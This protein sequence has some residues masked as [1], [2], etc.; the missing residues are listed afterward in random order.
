MGTSKLNIENMVGAYPV[1][2]CCQKPS[3][4]R[5]AWAK[6]NV[7]TGEWVLKS[8]FDKYGC[9][10]CGEEMTPVWKLNEEFRQK[11][12][13]RLNDALRHGKCEHGTVVITSGLQ[14]K[15]QEYLTEVSQA[16]AGFNDFSEDNDPHLEHDFGATEINGDKIFWK[17][18]YLDLEMKN[19]SPDAANPAVTHRI[20]TI[21]FEHEY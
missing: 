18:D 13:Q 14:T 17:V 15:G 1:C 2:A 3:V 5:D 10:T 4:V 8:T 9:D 12:I 6:W 19:H 20:L 7:G 16:V 11:R 21:M